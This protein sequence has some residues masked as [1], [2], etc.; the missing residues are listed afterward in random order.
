MGGEENNKLT[1]ANLPSHSH[2]Q[3][4][5]TVYGDSKSFKSKRKTG[6]DSFDAVGT[7]GN[8]NLSARYTG[9]TGENLPHNNMPPYYAL[10]YIM[11]L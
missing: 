6:N 11:K 4:E 7:L 2:S 3:H 10:A 5:W 1:I 8:N 9:N